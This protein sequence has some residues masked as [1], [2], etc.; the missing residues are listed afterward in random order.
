MPVKE[1]ATSPRPTVK[2]PESVT[3]PETCGTKATSNYNYNPMLCSSSA[4]QVHCP[5]G[6][7]MMGNAQ[8][9]EA[10]PWCE[11]TPGYSNHLQQ[12]PTGIS[13]N[14][15]QT[16]MLCS[17]PECC[18]RWVGVSQPPPSPVPPPQPPFHGGKPAFCGS[19]LLYGNVYTLSP[20]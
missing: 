13:S 2:Q 6:Y 5:G 9:S 3:P 16:L 4:T 1:E 18:G 19:C 17:C 12:S 7:G 11:V 15:S 14:I 8:W 10:R 20:V